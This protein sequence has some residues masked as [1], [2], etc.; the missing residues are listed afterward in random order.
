MQQASSD[1]VA[2]QVALRCVPEWALQHR[3][4]QMHSQ[5]ERMRLPARGPL[6]IRAC[7]W[8]IE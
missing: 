8:F 2:L 3:G 7:V 6:S 1:Q 5:N 4:C